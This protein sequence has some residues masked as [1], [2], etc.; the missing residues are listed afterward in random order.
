M[1]DEGFKPAC[2]LKGLHLFADIFFVHVLQ[3][4]GKIVFLVFVSIYPHFHNVEETF[5]IYILPFGI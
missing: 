2:L 3:C 4:D 1:K 5:T